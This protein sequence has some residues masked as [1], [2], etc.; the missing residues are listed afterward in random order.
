MSWMHRTSLLS[1]PLQSWTCIITLCKSGNALE[2][3]QR[4]HE[5]A[6]LWDITFCTRW[7]FKNVLGEEGDD[8]E[9]GGEGEEEEGEEEEVEE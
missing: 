3:V 7:F 4:V 2:R 1:T 9:D 6:Y 5:P 8:D